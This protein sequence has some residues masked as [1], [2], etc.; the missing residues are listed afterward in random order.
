MQRYRTTTRVGLNS[1]P[2]KST[3][4]AI[5]GSIGMFGFFLTQIT[6][7]MY[8]FYL[9]GIGL[10]T[11]DNVNKVYFVALYSI[12]MLAF[13]MVK[14]DEAAA[15]RAIPKIL[16]LIQRV[17]SIDIDD[18]S[19]E[20]LTKEVAA[21]AIEFKD[22]VF[23][24][25]SRPDVPVLKGIS[26]T[27]SPGQT[28]ALVGASGSGKSTIVSLLER[29]YDPMDG[30]ITIGGRD[31]TSMP[32]K[33]LREHLGIVTQEPVLFGTSIKSNIRYGSSKQVSDEEIA[34][35]AKKA[36]I[37]KFVEELPDKYETTVGSRG[38]QLSGG[39]KQRVAIARA[40]IR[41]PSV[42]LL[43]EATSALDTESEAVVQG[44]LDNLMKNCTT[45]VIAHR[46]STIQNADCIYVI[47]SG[48][49]VDHGNHQTLLGSD[50]EIYRQLVEKQMV[51][52]S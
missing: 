49:V 47:D 21:G 8:A 45:I 12:M 23:R 25:P 10:Y 46:L 41:E 42:L 52:G 50:C 31:I 26:L 11:I 38:S 33:S 30:T 7:F 44:A 43:D 13:T 28:V 48:K 37:S 5:L 18:E 3:I 22:I 20:N 27:V 40:V 4:A 39:Q 29:F 24:Y 51:K 19:G 34:I 9:L 36:N 32:I 16:K 6:V 2:C 17:P 15:Q 1:V 14:G 35:A